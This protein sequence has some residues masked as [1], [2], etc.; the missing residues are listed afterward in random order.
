MAARISFSFG[1][2]HDGSEGM[3]V[4]MNSQSTR[5]LERR[6]MKCPCP[7]CTLPKLASVV[8]M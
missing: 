3:V 6:H 8:Y 7:W 2:T 5:F 4:P 1:S